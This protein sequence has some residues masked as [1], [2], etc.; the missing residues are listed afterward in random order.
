MTPKLSVNAIRSLGFDWPKYPIIEEYCVM[1]D[2]KVD[3]T[4]T[5][6]GMQASR[7]VYE[8]QLNAAFAFKMQSGADYS[9][10]TDRFDD[11]AR[12]H[13]DLGVAI[14][15]LSEIVKRVLESPCGSR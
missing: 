7:A 6:E 12:M 1:E 9:D 15:Y 3:L 14:T 13:R 10:F 4:P 5:I 2:G 11:Y 8:G